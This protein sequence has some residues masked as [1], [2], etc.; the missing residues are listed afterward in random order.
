MFLQ[1]KSKILKLSFFDMGQN[2]LQVSAAEVNKEVLWAA[3]SG[4][5]RKK[6]RTDSFSILHLHLGVSLQ[7]I[8]NIYSL[9]AQAPNFSCN[10]ESNV[11]H[12]FSLFQPLSESRMLIISQ[13][14]KQYFFSCKYRNKL[15]HRVV[16]NKVLTFRTLVLRRSNTFSLEKPT[17]PILVFT[18]LPFIYFFRVCD[19]CWT[20]VCFAVRSQYTQIFEITLTNA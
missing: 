12:Y 5:S 15:A 14:N 20:V 11:V 7:L 10:L 2:C 16:E 19:L 8:W 1:P 3:Y 6:C 17:Q 18:S 4:H 9:R 13:S